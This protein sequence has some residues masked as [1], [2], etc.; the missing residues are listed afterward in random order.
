MA[1]A[2]KNRLDEALLGE[3]IAVEFTGKF[4]LLKLT[5]KKG[6]GVFV[7]AVKGHK[8]IVQHYIVF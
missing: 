6:A 7:F 5:V 1:L 8:R 4:L 2:Q 3:V